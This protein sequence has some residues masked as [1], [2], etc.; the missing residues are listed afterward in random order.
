MEVTRCGALFHGQVA[1][2]VGGIKEVCVGTS[3]H[4]DT[5]YLLKRYRRGLWDHLRC[6]YVYK[7][8]GREHWVV[9][10]GSLVFGPYVFLLRTK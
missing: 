4:T 1:I 5:I 8:H 9:I 2:V 6:L 3:E 10:S 7:R